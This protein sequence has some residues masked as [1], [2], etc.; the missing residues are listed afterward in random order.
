MLG[1]EGTLSP[2]MR[3]TTLRGT[4]GRHLSLLG[5]RW[6]HLL[7]RGEVKGST[8][9]QGGGFRR[10]YWQYWG[11]QEPGTLGGLLRPPSPLSCVPMLQHCQPS[12]P[13]APHAY[14]CLERKTGKT[15]SGLRWGANAAGKAHGAL[16]E[17]TNLFCRE[18]QVLSTPCPAA[19]HS[20]SSRRVQGPL[21]L[22]LLRALVGDLDTTSP[23]HLPGIRKSCL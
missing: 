16:R 10:E 2:G 13:H 18:P 8:A 3:S 1:E 9:L 12:S 5:L 4:L 17:Q 11:T 19:C 7:G 23:V 21:Q 15:G 20:L 6:A 22:L 14:Q